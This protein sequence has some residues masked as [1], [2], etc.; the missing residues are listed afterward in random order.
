MK[1][2]IPKI[3]NCSICLIVNIVCKDVVALLTF[4]R[5]VVRKS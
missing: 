3:I 2:G 5:I 4:G 1:F